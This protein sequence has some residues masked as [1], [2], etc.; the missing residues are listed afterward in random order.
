VRD[1]RGDA[2]CARDLGLA[3]RTSSNVLII[4]SI[5]TRPERRRARSRARANVAVLAIQRAPR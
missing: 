2:A 1:A 5:T 3:Q 4:G